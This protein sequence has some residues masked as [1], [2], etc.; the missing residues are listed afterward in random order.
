RNTVRFDQAIGTALTR[1]AG[2]FIE[3]SAHPALLMPMA[4]LV[5][6]AHPA[7]EA[8]VLLSSSRRDESVLDHLPAAIT[9]AAVADPSYRGAALPPPPAGPPP[10]GSPTPPR[11]PTHLGARPEPRRDV[12]PAAPRVAHEVWQT[13]PSAPP[14]HPRRVSVAAAVDADQSAVD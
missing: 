11:R 5:D 3:L 10:R 1:G 6:E 14:S 9:A 8:A 7:A 12:P 13:R 4:D 2:T